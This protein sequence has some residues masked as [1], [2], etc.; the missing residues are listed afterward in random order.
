MTLQLDDNGLQIDTYDELFGVLAD[1][2]RGIYGA[3]INLDPESPDGQRVGIFARGLLDIQSVLALLINQLDPDLATGEGLNRLIKLAGIARSPATRS[4]VDATVTASKVLILPAGFEVLDDLGQL[5]AT[6]SDQSLAIG[7]NTVTLYAVEFGAVTAEAGTIT[8]PSTIVS[9][10]ASVTNAAA[11][12]AGRDEETDEALRIRRAAAV[13]SPS[14]NTLGKLYSVIGQLNGVTDLLIY[15]ND[16]A[17]TDA[18]RSIDPHTLWVI[19]EGGEVADIVEALALNKPGGTGLK[20][21]TSGDYATTVV[22]PSGAELPLVHTYYF[23]RPSGVNL[24]VELTVEHDDAGGVVDV[25]AVKAAIVSRGAAIAEALS[26]GDLYEYAY[27]PADD[28]TVT[29]LK[30]SDDDVTYTD[31]QLSPGYSS[32]FALDAARI[33]ITDITPP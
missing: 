20:G 7:A 11:A 17:A 14:Q 4:Q 30:I 3:D 23:D 12:T 10:V 1:G 15:E 18:V 21:S 32:R 24:Y 31:G 19:V 5:W 6:Q 25:D 8:T 33:T 26:A 16:T 27:R 13:Q 2:L 28:Y 22:L 29:L 9:G